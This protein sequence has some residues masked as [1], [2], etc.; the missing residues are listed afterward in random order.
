ME[1]RRKRKAL[2]IWMCRSRAEGGQSQIGLECLSLYRGKAL[3]RLAVDHR[4]KTAGSRS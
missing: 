2:R 1:E 4:L 3:D